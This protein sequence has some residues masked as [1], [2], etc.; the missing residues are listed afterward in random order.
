M[1]DTRTEFATGDSA[2]DYYITQIA[3]HILNGEMT[4]D[5]W[6]SAATLGGIS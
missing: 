5:M 6:N 2:M 4:Y 1:T 3:I